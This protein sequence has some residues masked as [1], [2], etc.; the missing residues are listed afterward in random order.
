[1]GPIKP[2]ID[3]VGEG[4]GV[5]SIAIW[6]IGRAAIAVPGSSGIDNRGV[7]DGVGE[8]RDLASCNGLEG[9]VLISDL[10]S[11]PSS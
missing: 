5:G 4:S 11:N 2:G 3:A 10:D 9:G 8:L 7:A 6:I 1:M